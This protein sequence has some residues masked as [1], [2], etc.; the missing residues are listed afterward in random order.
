MA[1]ERFPAMVLISPLWAMS[2]KGWALSQEV[3]VAGVLEIQVEAV[4]VLGPGE[5]LVDDRSRRE[6]GE[7]EGAGDP[8]L[9]QLGAEHLL[10]VVEQLVEGGVRAAVLRPPQDGVAKGRQGAPGV[11]PEDGGVGGHL[12]EGQHLE[13]EE[14]EGGPEDGQGLLELEEIRWGQQAG[15]GHLAPRV[16]QQVEGDVGHHS[17]P[18]A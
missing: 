8:G 15:D 2:R 4:Q 1:R 7:I 10:G 18:V 16:A 6:R 11:L 5:G 13:V 9:G 12:P 14:V 17:G 3:R